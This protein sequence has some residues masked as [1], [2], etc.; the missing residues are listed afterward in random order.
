MD[1]KNYTLKFFTFKLLIILTLLFSRMIY[2]QT[3]SENVKEDSAKTGIRKEKKEEKEKGFIIYSDRGKS[4]LKVYGEVRLNGALDLNGL[5]S[6]ETFN[7]YEIQVDVP[8]S[9]EKKFYLG[10][11]QSRIGLDANINTSLGMMNAKIE[12]DF[13]GSNNSFRIRQSYA[14]IKAF[15][16]GKTRSLFGD[17]D[18]MP[19]KVDRDG[20]N[21]AMSE[22]TIQL[23]YEPK[24]KSSLKW[25]VAIE[26]PEADITGPPDDI[27][28]DPYY[29]SIPPLISFIQSDFDNGNHLRLSG[30]FRNITVRN[31][32]QQLQILLGYGALFSGSIRLNKKNLVNFQVFGGQSISRYVKSFKGEGEDVVFDTVSN[33]YDP[34]NLTGGFASLSHSWNEWLTSDITYGLSTLEEIQSQ[35]G[36]TFRLGYYASVNLFFRSFSTSEVGIEYSF[37]KKV[38]MN[39]DFGTANRVSFIMFFHF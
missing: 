5:Q 2:S 31:T 28:I 20:P 12:G 4:S 18:A 36:T 8:D 1:N 38:A 25:G 9:Y 17:A 11:F 15:L 39:E 7:V 29:Q 14:K 23:R 33:T 16:G 35:P 24:I 3:D 6:Q 34:V 21:F 37:G 19:T 10:V 22:R 32:D 27:S 30:I 13:N 26:N